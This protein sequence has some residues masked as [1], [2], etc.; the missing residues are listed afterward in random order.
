MKLVAASRSFIITFTVFTLF[1]SL[2]LKIGSGGV[3]LQASHPKISECG[4][5]KSILP[6]ESMLKNFLKPADYVLVFSLKCACCEWC[7]INPSLEARTV[8]SGLTEVGVSSLPQ[9]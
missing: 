7:I 2:H 4:L 1:T 3:P 6:Q 5:P 9:T 8:K